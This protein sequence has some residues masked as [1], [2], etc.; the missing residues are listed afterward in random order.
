MEEKT[1]LIVTLTEKISSL[2]MFAMFVVVMLGIIARYV[3]AIPI[4]WTDELSRFLMFY[5]VML[6]GSLAIREDSHPSLT[7]VTDRMPKKMKSI[8]DIGLQILI[9]ICLLVIVIYGIEQVLDSTIKK[10]AGLRLS[11]SVV[12]FGF[13][14]GGTLMIVASL[15]KIYTKIKSLGCMKE[16]K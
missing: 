11:Y 8:W 2:F 5:V 7:F 6:G 3:L 12:Y 14:L 13:P 16:Q 15:A 10:S 1:P 4:F 9:I